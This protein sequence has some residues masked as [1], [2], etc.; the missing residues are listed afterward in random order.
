MFQNGHGKGKG[1][2][3]GNGNG[4][5]NKNESKCNDDLEND[6]FGEP[7]SKKRRK[8]NN[9]Q[10]HP[11]TN[12]NGGNVNSTSQTMS[13]DQNKN[14]NVK[15]WQCNACTY[16][17]ENSTSLACEICG[18]SKN[19]N[20]KII[21]YENTSNGHQN[22][23]DTKSKDN[24]KEN[25]NSNSQQL[26]KVTEKNEKNV[27][28]GSDKGWTCQICTFIQTNPNVTHCEICTTPRGV[29]SVGVTNNSALSAGVTIGNDDNSND[30][31]K[32]NETELTEEKRDSGNDNKN[33]TGNDKDND[34]DDKTSV[35]KQGNTDGK[36]DIFTFVT[37]NVWFREELEL[38]AR[39]D[40]I[41]M[42]IIKYN[43]DCVALQEVTP[44]IFEIIQSSNWFLNNNYRF[45]KIMKSIE[46]LPYFCV[47]L[48]KH[49]FVSGETG[50]GHFKNS[51]MHRYFI[52]AGLKYKNKK[53]VVATTH[54]ESPVG[55]YQGGKKDKFKTERLEQFDVVE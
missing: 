41:G 52:V 50:I 45:T 11:F 47:L 19:S 48:S 25:D 33:G 22:K 34:T 28:N 40:A 16:I 6:D 20:S 43:A 42:N 10:K 7:P 31:N 38:K 39:I 27:K 51:R 44:N 4:N 30:K 54:L 53:L 36:D 55:P 46:S 9:S 35:V 26:S 2:G 23:N 49:E 29:S 17:Q 5:K 18:A 1:K 15:S 8:L 37:W 12:G 13:N 21:Y 14:K 3:S 32:T 24:G